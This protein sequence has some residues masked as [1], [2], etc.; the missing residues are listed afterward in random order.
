MEPTQRSHEDIYNR[1]Q[2][3]DLRIE[4]IDGKLDNI[5]QLL[6][7]R[8]QASVE[9]RATSDKIL[10][11]IRRNANEHAKA[12][13]ERFGMTDKAIEHVRQSYASDIE[14]HKQRNENDLK[15]LSKTVGKLDGKLLALGGGIGL[16]SFFLVM[17]APVIQ[18]NF[19]R[20][21]PANGS[22][23]HFELRR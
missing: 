23:E 4:R 11:E 21:A 15:E 20:V 13:W 17:F 12:V 8:N 6:H 7:L 14:A 19:L 2:A 22:P 1:Q 5:T 16:L 3:T 9:H 10:E 18:Q